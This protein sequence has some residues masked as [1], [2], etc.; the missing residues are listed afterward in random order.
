MNFL[1]TKTTPQ[2]PELLPLTFSISPTHS[3][4]PAAEITFTLNQHKGTVIVKNPTELKEFLLGPIINGVVDCSLEIA[5]AQAY[6]SFVRAQQSVFINETHMR[7]WIFCRFKIPMNI[8]V[9]KTTEDQTKLFEGR[10]EAY[11]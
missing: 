7:L 9:P 11:Y 4:A 2:V 8:A 1:G 10:F 6:Q 3:E 5:S